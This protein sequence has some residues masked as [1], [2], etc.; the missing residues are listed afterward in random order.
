MGIETMASDSPR[1]WQLAFAAIA[2]RVARNTAADS[3]ELD[4]LKHQ[5]TEVQKVHLQWSDAL[6]AMLQKPSLADVR[7]LNLAA[8]IELAPLEIL[9]VALAAAIEDDPMAGRVL[10][11]VQAPVGGARPTLGLL[12][13]ALASL[14]K[15][16]ES[17]FAV[18]L[19]GAALRTGLIALANES[20]PLPERA[21]AVPPPLCLALNS[22]PSDWPGVRIGLE[23]PPVPLAP[24][25][26]AVASRHAHALQTG[27]V[28][29]LVLRAGSTME[30]QTIAIALG[31]ALGRSAV[32]AETDKL[33]GFGVWLTLQGLLP[34]FMTNLGPSERKILP[35]L[36]GYTG[37][38]LVIAGRDGV[39]E[40]A[41][42]AL[43][44][45][46]IEVPSPGERVELWKSTLP[47]EAQSLAGKLGN[48][49]RHSA[50]RIAQ[51]GR[52]ARHH[53]ALRQSTSKNTP[54]LH[55]A[56][57]TAAA[58][59]MEGTGLDSLAEP[60]RSAIPDEALVAPA[61]LRGQLDLLA[62][63]CRARDGLADGLGIAAATRYRSGVRALFCGPSGTGKTLAAGWLATRL[64]LPLYRIDLASV[65]SKYIGETEKNL[66]QLLSQAEN[67]EV[68]LLFDEAD[69]LF[70]KRTD[71][72]DSND[73]F[74]NAQTNYL[75]QRIESYDGIVLLTS[76]SRERFDSAFTRRL[77]FILEFP[78]PDPGERRAL[79]IAHLGENHSLTP[80]ELNQLSGLLDFTGGHIRNAVFTAAVIARSE[81][82]RIT[83]PDVIHGAAAE[84]RK[85]GRQL[86]LELGGRH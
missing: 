27:N 25:T 59:T 37:P 23:M 1:L 82:R 84:Y 7:L 12:T 58:W 38:V 44:A 29:A 53:A 75:L 14:L 20:A 21:V 54:D 83:F 42:G 78:L 52:L 32:F 9:T 13:T 4:Y 79:W 11:R 15:P 17:P 64:G 74:A 8:D 72:R 36:P 41:Q 16:T 77:D 57:I 69:S 56:D 80:I 28:K 19:N 66:A 61:S 6:L 62:L 49:H 86:P 24:S 68:I 40:N 67:A 33:T 26:L 63:R 48:D 5:L 43:P 3:P 10:A 73:R 35:R 65:T 46:V 18:L 51:L 81:G 22:H 31:R 55:M 71:I 30:A 39:V 47:S 60:Q 50:G 45:W 2:D 34:V 70:G 85:Q 76:N